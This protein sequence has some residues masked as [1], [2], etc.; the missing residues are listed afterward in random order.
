MKQIDSEAKEHFNAAFS[1]LRARGPTPN[2]Q[3]EP[4]TGNEGTSGESARE[5]SLAQAVAELTKAIE[6][7]KEKQADDYSQAYFQRALLYQMMGKSEEAIRD[8]DKVVELNP[9]EALSY[10]LRGA[11]Y[12]LKLGDHDRAIQDLSKA[13]ELESGNSLGSAYYHRAQAYRNSTQT[14]RLENAIK[15]Y[16]VVIERNLKFG[17]GS[18]YVKRGAV[19]AELR[20]WDKAIADFE[21]AILDN[22]AGAVE[23]YRVRAVVYTRQNKDDQA[24]E[25]I[26]VALDMGADPEELAREIKEAKAQR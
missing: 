1:I 14:G 5:S 25:D 23:A 6:I 9:G 24:K 19:Y 21:S 3:K 16:D 2:T 15:D 17:V 13:I 4:A 18:V 26:K 12:E 20:Q 11:I 7:Q 22:P 10:D 8:A